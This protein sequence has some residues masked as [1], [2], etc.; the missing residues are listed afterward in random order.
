[1]LAGGR[2]G[3]RIRPCVPSCAPRSSTHGRPPE[4]ARLLHRKLW[5][6]LPAGL[7]R[8]AM[9]EQADLVLDG[10]YVEPARLLAEGYSFHYP[11]LDAALENLLKG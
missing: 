5:L 7:M 6:S 2:C 3:A 10:Q 1:M 4:P 11:T 8:T 9:G